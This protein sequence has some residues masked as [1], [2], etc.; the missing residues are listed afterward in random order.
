MTSAVELL[1]LS[2]ERD[3]VCAGDD[4]DAPHRVSI[5][6][7]S[8]STLAQVLEVIQ[9]MGYLAHIAGG[10]ATWIVE[11]DRPLAV[12]AEQWKT[13]RFLIASET[14]IAACQTNDGSRPL[15]FRY[16]CQVDPDRVFDCLKAGQPLPDQYGRE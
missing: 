15:F 5:Q 9:G 8:E 10:C 7:H 1:S 14:R 11:S 13:P 3:S 12:M 16:W 2:I 4:C 6:V